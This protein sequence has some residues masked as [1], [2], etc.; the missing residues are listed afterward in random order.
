MSMYAE[1][2]WRWGCQYTYYKTRLAAMIVV[3][4][5]MQVAIL[6]H[7]NICSTTTL[8]KLKLGFVHKPPVCLMHQRFAYVCQSICLLQAYVALVQT[9]HDVK[10]VS[11]PGYVQSSFQ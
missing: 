2:D 3:G 9:G 7:H 10:G 5:I 6:Q 11:T 4:T 8:V 1:E